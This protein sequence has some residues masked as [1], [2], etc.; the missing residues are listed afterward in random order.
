MVKLRFGPIV[1]ETSLPRLEEGRSGD[2][3]RCGSST[4][5]TM[6]RS[7]GLKSPFGDFRC[8]V[9]SRLDRDD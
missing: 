9:G 5:A 1:V 7:A 6:A 2:L 3:L 8:A 4:L